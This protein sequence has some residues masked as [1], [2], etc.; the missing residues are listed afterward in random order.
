M[1]LNSRADCYA[2]GDSRSEA[3]KAAF[4]K[5]CWQSKT[6]FPIDTSL[7]AFVKL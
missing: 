2:I 1:R 5:F 6:A 3:S 7:K 4:Y